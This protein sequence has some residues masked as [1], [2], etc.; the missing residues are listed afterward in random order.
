MIRTWAIFSEGCISKLPSG[1][2]LCANYV[3]G[4]SVRCITMFLSLVWAAILEEFLNR[5]FVLGGLLVSSLFESGLLVFMFDFVGHHYPC[6]LVSIGSF[7]A[8]DVG[9]TDLF[10]VLHIIFHQ[11]RWV[12]Y[13]VVLFVCVFMEMFVFW[14]GLSFPSLT[15]E[16]ISSH[17]ADV[18]LSLLCAHL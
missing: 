7:S 14:R 2:C 6:P 3:C 10:H 8:H 18:E 4:S 9:H 5:V 13:F 1:S 16:Q 11:M 17:F 15:S 12:F